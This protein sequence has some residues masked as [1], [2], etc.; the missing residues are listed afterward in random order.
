MQ[1]F[2]PLP[3]F[4]ES[5]RVLDRVRLGNQRVEALQ[6]LRALRQ[7]EFCLYDRIDREYLYGESL[8]NIG[9]GRVVRVT[10][11][12]RHSTTRMWIGYEVALILYTVAV[13]NEWIGRG[14]KDTCLGKALD[15]VKYFNNTA[16]PDWFGDP[17]VHSSHRAALLAKNEDWYSKF[18]WPEIPKINY[19]WPK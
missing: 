5:A 19:F 15:Y 6:M 13:C 17:R 7:G 12:F 8:E 10:P 2:L 1:T 9:N 3:D 4:Q 14:Y 16:M 18:N 11:R